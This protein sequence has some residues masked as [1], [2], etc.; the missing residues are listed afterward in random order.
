MCHLEILWLLLQN[1]SCWRKWE[2]SFWNG[3]EEKQEA[4]TFSNGVCVFL[5]KFR[6]ELVFWVSRL[7]ARWLSRLFLIARVT[8]S[9]LTA[10]TRERGKSQASHSWGGRVIFYQ[11]QCKWIVVARF[12]DLNPQF[13]LPFSFRKGFL[14]GCI[15]I[16]DYIFLPMWKEF[17]YH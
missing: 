9:S 1:P 5:S 2:F 7:L 12:G 6:R 14:H 15:L 13:A 17:Q 8:Q 4:K 10:P 11:S 16:K 3:M